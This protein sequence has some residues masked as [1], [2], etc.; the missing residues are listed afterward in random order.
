MALLES[1]VGR[2]WVGFG[3][4][5][6]YPNPV[7]NAATLAYG[8]CCDHAF[9][10]G[11]KRTALVAML[12]HLDR[13]KWSLFEVGQNALYALIIDVAEHTLG[14]RRKQRMKSGRRDP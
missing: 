14:L 2:Q 9:H 13:N 8:L 12:V 1:A 10:N 3:D 5:L 7:E 11:N 6:K 4:R